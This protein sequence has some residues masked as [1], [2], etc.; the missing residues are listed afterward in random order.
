MITYAFGSG[1]Q[2]RFFESRHARECLGYIEREREHLGRWRAW[3]IET[4]TVESAEAFLRRGSTGSVEDGL[5][6]AGIWLNDEMEGGALFLPLDKR[7]QSTEVGYL[8][9][10]QAMAQG[11]VSCAMWVMLEHAIEA[12]RLNR[13]AH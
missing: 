8:L 4:K 6:W 1:A 5:P 12:I 11:L 7:A 9:S 13:V 3:A 10:K 2:L